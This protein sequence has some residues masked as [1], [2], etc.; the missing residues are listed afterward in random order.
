MQKEEIPLR[1]CLGLLEPSPLVL[2][3]TEVRDTPNVSTCSWIMPA[4]LTPPTLALSLSP[5]SLTR[6][7]IEDRGEFIANIPGRE[8]AREAAFCGSVSGR[9]VQKWKEC[10]L[11]LEPG[12]RVRAPLLSDCIAHLECRAVD[13]RP[14]GGNIVFAAEVVLALVVRGGFEPS[15]GW[16]LEDPAARFLL[17]LGGSCYASPERVVEVDPMRGQKW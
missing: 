17:H 4:G 8:L 7:N 1:G 2:V 12:G 16:N 9:E 10:R 14:W 11:R 13:S 15:R 6:R 5:E 3:T